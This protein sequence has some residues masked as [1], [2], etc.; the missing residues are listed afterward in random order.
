MTNRRRNS[1]S[2]A[3]GIMVVATTANGTR[4]LQAPRLTAP[5]AVTDSYYPFKTCKISKDD[6]QCQLGM[7]TFATMEECCQKSFGKDGCTDTSSS[8]RCWIPG[9]YHPQTSCVMSNDSSKCNVE[10]GHWDTW[11]DCCASG[12]T[13]AFPGGCSTEKPC[14]TATDFYPEKACGFTSD[15]SICQRGWGTFK[16]L[17]ECCA[18][19]NGF[20]TG[21]GPA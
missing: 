19:G 3:M 7:N 21:C 14:F 17:E 11:E 1:A 12:G 5:C 20:T 9:E 18:P 13:G 2:L 10:W 15:Q 6:A 4:T 8:A 16:S